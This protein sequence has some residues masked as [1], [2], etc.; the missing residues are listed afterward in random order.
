MHQTLLMLMMCHNI[1]YLPIRIVTF[2][3]ALINHLSLIAQ[4]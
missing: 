3:S 1:F 4:C 2:R